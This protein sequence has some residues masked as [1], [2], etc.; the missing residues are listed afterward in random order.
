MDSSEHSNKFDGPINGNKFMD[1][2]KKIASKECLYTS[3]LVLWMDGIL[4]NQN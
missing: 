2:L 3:L 1:W 4:Y